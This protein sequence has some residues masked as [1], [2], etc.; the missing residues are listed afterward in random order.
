MT[1]R[2]DRDR[3]RFVGRLHGADRACKV[4]RLVKVKKVRAGRDVLIGRDVTNDRGK[5][6]VARTG[7]RGKS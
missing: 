7:A 3:G 4:D 1:I 2:Y 5:W 6:R